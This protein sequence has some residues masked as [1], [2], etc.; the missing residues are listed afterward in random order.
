MLRSLRF[1]LPALFLAGIVIAGFVSVAIAFQLLQSYSRSQSLKELRKEAAGLNTL[2]SQQATAVIDKGSAAPAI[3]PPQLEKATGDRIYYFGIPPFPGEGDG[4]A[5]LRL[6]PADAR[7]EI[8]LARIKAGHTQSFDFTPPNDR[9]LTGVAGPLTAGDTTLGVLVIAKPQTELRDTWVTLMKFFGISI[10]GGLV[11]AGVLA[12]YASRRITKPV[13]GLSAAADEIARGNYNVQMPQVTGG[14]EI[15]HLADR[16]REMAARLAETEERERNFLM[17]VSHE[18]RT[19][20]T[21]IR[22]HV[23][24]MREGLTTDPADQAASLDV[25][26]TATARLERLVGDV[27][28]LAKLDAHRFTVLREEV[29]MARLLDQAYA[30]YGEEARRR[31]ID[32]RCEID[33]RPV[34]VTD[35]DR[36]LQ[37]ISN[38]LSNAFR[39]TPDGGRV[40]L[41]LTAENGS[42]SVVVRDSGPG[43]R[44]EERERIFR[45]FFSGDQSRDGGGTGLGLAIARELAVALG[46]RL[47]LDTA[48]GEG[49]RFRLI[50]PVAPAV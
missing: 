41:G 35:G 16:F 20:L 42:V 18:L 12:W 47:E 38:L 37:I 24:A 50:L 43:V 23:E 19:P 17:T 27:L 11:V 40:D 49:S 2:L 21:A 34:V 10:L 9:G 4:R 25:V 48:P 8:D 46:G 7:K 44:P 32:Y 1:R 30:A 31:A 5:G 26:A 22:G 28:D 3:E 33:E 6:L 45:P 14:D 13:L 29:D 15:S 39:W 36:V